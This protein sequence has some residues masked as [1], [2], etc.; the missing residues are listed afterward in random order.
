M[1]PPVHRYGDMDMESFD[2]YYSKWPVELSGIPKAVVQ[3]WVYRH[4]SCFKERWISLQPHNWNYRLCTFTNDD[5]LAI[6]HVLTWIPELDAEGVEFVTGA[7][8]SQGRLGQFMLANGTFP[9]PIIVA[10]NA[11]HIVCPRSGGQRMKTP[12][13]LIEGHARLACIRGMI[14]SQHP[15]LKSEHQVWLVDIP[16]GGPNNSFKAD[17]SAAA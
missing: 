14:N 9:M 3:D 2:S 13:Q 11:S 4:W 16:G 6:D 17:G 12:L 10:E 5:V 1:Y 7:P 8:R 15:N